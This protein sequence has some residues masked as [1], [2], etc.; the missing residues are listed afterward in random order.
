MEELSFSFCQGRGSIEHN[1][2]QLKGKGVRQNGIKQ[3]R[4][5]NDVIV[6]KD[7]DSVLRPLVCP[8]IDAYNEKV[9]VKHPERMITYEQWKAKQCYTRGGKTKKLYSEYVVQ[10]GDRVSGCPYAYITR[11]GVAVDKNGKTIVPWDTRNAPVAK[12]DANGKEVASQ[13]QKTFKRLYRDFVA[14]FQKQNPRAIVTCAVVHCD[15][16]GGMHLHL[17]V[18][19]LSDTR[20][21]IGL[22]LGR[23]TAIQQQTGYKSSCKKLTAEKIWTDNI[24]DELLPAVCERYGIKRRDMKQHGRRHLSIEEYYQFADSRSEALAAVGYEQAKKFVE[25]RWS[26][27][28][29]RYPEIAK[30]VQ[31]EVVAKFGREKTKKLQYNNNNK[32]TFVRI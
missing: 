10:I 1:L 20:T 3:R 19:W 4:H 16:N 6:N 31:A 11:N 30:E 8:R 21:G 14:A 29:E 27:L 2:R 26:V 22:G 25:N 5:W 23:T 17:D 12:L 13:R 28:E 15:E 9:M 7:V 32:N 24:R 18:L